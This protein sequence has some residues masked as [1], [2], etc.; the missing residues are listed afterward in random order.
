MMDLKSRE[1]KPKSVIKFLEK[2]YRFSMIA[3]ILFLVCTIL[4]LLLTIRF[5]ELNEIVWL[6]EIIAKHAVFV[7][8][9]IF[10]KGAETGYSPECTCPWSIHIPDSIGV[11]I[12]NGCT[13]IFAMSIF[14]TI[15]LF[16]PHSQEPKARGEVVWRKILA[17]IAALT[18]IYLYNVFRIAIQ[19]NLYHQGFDW[20]I[21]HDSVGT[22]SITVSIHLLIFLISLL[23]V[24]EICISILYPFKLLYDRLKKEGP[25]V[26][27]YDINQSS[28]YFEARRLFKS[29]GMDLYL[30]DNYDIEFRL[31]KFLKENEDKFTAKAIRNRLFDR[32]E[33]ITEEIVEKVLEIL[34][35]LKIVLSE[36]HE[37]KIYYYS[38]ESIHK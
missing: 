16:A 3:L 25:V 29:E 9:L 32:H 22:L 10:N 1:Q 11:Y 20:H 21:V 18:L 31:I 8:N 13:G 23:L 37:N 19:V 38:F 33:K 36:I 5:L 30:I 4:I 6:H 17:I 35:H 2:K 26:D 7:L 27:N 28:Q 24:P 12:D 14:V 34:T 15:I